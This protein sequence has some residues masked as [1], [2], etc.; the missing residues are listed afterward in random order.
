MIYKL[1]SFT[2]IASLMAWYNPKPADEKDFTISGKVTDSSGEVLIGANIAL[3]GTNSGTVTDINGKFE[4]ITNDSCV[5]VQIHYIGFIIKKE[6]MCAGKDHTLIL[7]ESF[8]NL[9]E[10]VII[11]YGIQRQKAQTSASVSSTGVRTK[12]SSKQ[13]PQPPSSIS[14]QPPQHNTENY[15]HIEENRFHRVSQEPLSTFSIDVDAAS[16]SNLRRFIND[17]Q[18]PPADAVRIEEMINY[19]DYDYP[20]PSSEHPFSI[21]AELGACPWE[22]KHQ[23]LHLGL[24]GRH[25]PAEKLPKANL[26]F[27]VDVS[28]S[29][30]APNKLALVQSS[31]KLLVE[32]LRPEDRVAM[33]VYAG[34]A[35][36]VLES[37]A[38]S[39]KTKI[40]EAID[41][42]QA[43]GSTAGGEGIKLAYKIAQQNLVKSGNNRVIL[44]TDGDFNVGVS[45]DGDLVRMIEEERKSGVFL[46]VLGYGMGNYQDNKMQQLADKGN[47]NHAYIDNL[48]EARKTLV[49]EFGGTMYTIAKDVKLQ[50]EFNPAQVAGYRLVGY[51]N[52]VLENEDFDD[53]QKDAG[54]LGAGHTVTAL[55]ELIPAGVES[56]LLADDKPL[57]YQEKVETPK[58]NK[59]TTKELLTVKFRYKAPDGDKSELLEEVVMADAGKNKAGENFYWSAAVAEFGMLLRA[60]KFK[61]N[62]SYESC[63]TLAKNARG[64][65]D[66]GY[67]A[68]MIRLL[69]AVALLGKKELRAE[70]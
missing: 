18:A 17:G 14:Y 6:V 27:L 12:R 42:L 56:K 39:Q 23:L 60:S 13:S 45:S 38:G 28:G 7:E 48:D 34:A 62:S 40:R 65:D 15:A 67:R 70:K 68:E 46:T 55:Y 64:K 24:Q 3:V 57:K 50:L 29:M 69:E 30:D 53:D 25:I 10:V 4:L 49:H 36:V 51:E 2:L 1:L 32:Q 33:V 44:C 52:R 37:T 41:Q 63:K 54:E 59:N 35:G 19:F 21:T 11:G 26:V 31:L 5:E 43:G 20:E 61:G 9:D 22:P 66:E 58:Q 16:Y 8:Q 47:G